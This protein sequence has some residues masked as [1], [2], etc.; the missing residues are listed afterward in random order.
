MNITC[1]ITSNK[2]IKYWSNRFFY[3]VISTAFIEHSLYTLI[4]NFV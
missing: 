3:L 2:T 1:T 4:N